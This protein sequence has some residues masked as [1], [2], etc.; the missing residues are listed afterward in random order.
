MLAQ[1]FK[2]VSMLLL[3]FSCNN[4]MSYGLFTPLHS[5]LLLLVIS[6]RE[7]QQRRGGFNRGGRTMKQQPP[8]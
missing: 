3:A 5:N 6:M 2:D 4:T 1:N 7:R 8:T